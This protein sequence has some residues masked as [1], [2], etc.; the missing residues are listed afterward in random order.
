MKCIK[1]D[2]EL[3]NDD[4]YCPACGKLTPHGYLYL[5]NTKN[6]INAKENN[7]GSL[8]TLT[9]IIIIACIITTSIRGKDMFKPYI[10]LKKE[11]YSI[12]YGY[13]VSLMNTNNE[14]NNQIINNKEEAI[15]FIKEDI[16]KTSW[17]CKKNT[18]VQII[19]K[20]ISTNYDIPIVSLCDVD[21]VVANKIKEVIDKTY[22]LFPNIK[23]HL[24]NITITNAKEGEEYIAF[25]EPLCTFTNNNVSIEQYNK[26]NKN[27]I[28]LNS[29]YF[30]NK[31]IL[32]K[33]LKENWYPTD[34]T[35][36][37]LIAHEIGHYIT[38]I[39]LL[40]ENNIDNLTLITKENI[41]DYYK[42][43]SLLKEQK[44]SKE[45]VQI[46]LN[47][48]NIKY[49]TS[50]TEK[51]FSSQISN[52]ASQLTN[53]GNVNYDEVL[54]EAIHDYYLHEEKS[55]KSTIE[56]VNVIKERLLI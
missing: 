3:E 14:Y 11:I 51:E 16:I 6:S 56:I 34:A 55:S 2:E 22:K 35:Y 13:N 24:T 40:K 31:N 9:A 18:K 43:Q 46:S 42:V 47:N 12:K 27:Q 38:Y 36:E 25:F 49:N 17:Q 52:Y 30:L 21:E 28:L 32:S 48:Y 33:G 1:C 19:E 54:A 5:K 10:A 53:K 37:T 23:G 26:V 7:I 45:L 4:N 44:Y 15:N 8:F 29:Y 39:T 50:I 41:E 20:E